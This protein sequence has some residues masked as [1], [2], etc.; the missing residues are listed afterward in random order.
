MPPEIH[1]GSRQEGG[2]FQGVK[3]QVKAILLDLDGTIFDISERDAFA[4]YEALNQL[5]H[6]VSLMSVKQHYRYGIGLTGTLEELG[7]RLTKREVERFLQARF[8]SFINMRNAVDLTRMHSGAH[9]ALA[10]LSQKHKLI[11]VTSR[12]RLSSVEKELQCFAIKR[13]FSLIVTR[14]VAARYHEV[15]KIDLFPFQPQRTKLYECVIGLTQTDP[16][17]MVCVGDSADEVEPARRMQMTA[18]G[19]LTGISSREDLEPVSD[20]VIQDI[21][22][23]HEILDRIDVQRHGTQFKCMNSIN[24]E[25]TEE[26]QD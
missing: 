15:E 20:Y 1:Q 17:Q 19:V 22:Y 21:T 3:D 2:N 5:G 4:C 8:I 9:A 25:R 24:H 12:N 10:H 7:I 26:Q 13:F 14:E 11:L 18:V 16:D 6:K 23:I